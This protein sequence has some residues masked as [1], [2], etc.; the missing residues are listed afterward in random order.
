[1]S[2]RLETVVELI[3][4]GRLEQA[5]QVLRGLANPPELVSL[6]ELKLSVAE[7]QLDPG[8]ALTSV[9]EFLRKSPKNPLAL[10]LYREFSLAQYRAGRSCLSHSHPPPAKA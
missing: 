9:V 5:R 3:D 10:G 2:D 4:E 7:Q 8:N 6:V 1:M